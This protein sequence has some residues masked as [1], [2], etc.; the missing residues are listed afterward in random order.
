[1]N[2]PSCGTDLPEAAKFC[3]S[4]GYQMTAPTAQSGGPAIASAGG[5]ALQTAGVKSYEEAAA[6][7]NDFAL[8]DTLKEGFELSKPYLG[9]LI[10]GFL[11]LILAMMAAGMIPFGSLVLG[12]PLLA[13]MTIVSLRIANGSPV[14]FGNFFDGFKKFVPLML[15][16]IVV[17]IL[18][19]LGAV[20][21]LIPG[22]YLAIAWSMA[23][24][25]CIDRDEDF[26]PAMMA[27]MQVVNG[28]FGKI[29]LW[30]LLLGAVN[31]VGA[32]ACGLGMF[33]T[34]PVT[35]VATAVFYKKLLGI[36][37]GAER[38]GA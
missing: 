20:L 9:L 25:I 8:M 31:F 30:M 6:D 24:T 37:G 7:V 2:C 13:G 16:N 4:C 23:T 14:E 34:A 35:G 22:L 17:G 26:W 1:M 11:V 33:V 28:N 29:F 19:G 36:Q 12:G 32:L 18:V 5:G 21:L 15:L 27:S 10:G 3:G 38:M